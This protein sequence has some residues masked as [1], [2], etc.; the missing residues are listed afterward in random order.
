MSRKKA[1]EALRFD[2]DFDEGPEPTVAPSPS[3]KPA[4]L[5]MARAALDG[6]GPAEVTAPSLP[7]GASDLALS[8]SGF[9]ERLR[10]ALSGSFPD[11]LWV[12]G[13]IRKVTVRNG[14][15][16]LELADHETTKPEIPA[17]RERYRFSRP[18]RSAGAGRGEATLEVS[19]WSKDWPRI[20]AALDSVGIELAPGLVVRVCG[21]V[22][23][24]EA[25][26]RI[27]FSLSALDVE[28][29]VGGIAASRRRL[30]RT[31]QAEGII[32]ANRKL[33]LSP[34][35]LR[36]GLVTSPS[37]DAYNDFT[38]RLA[39][40]GIKF[41]TRFEPSL[42]QGSDA[43]PQIATALARL[44]QHRL[45]LIVLVRGG[46][47]RGDLAA[48]DHEAVARAILASRCP[49]WTGI[50]HTGDQSVADEV[51]HRSL[52]TPTACAEEVIAVVRRYVDDLQ[53]RAARV[54]LV[55]GRALDNASG[56]LDR[57]R[58]QL[59]GA[60]RHEVSRADEALA[61]ERA[62]LRQGA[63]LALE[64]CRSS[65]ARRCGRA[66]QLALARLVAEG[67]RLVSR[68]ALLDAFDPKRQLER[69]WSLTKGTDGRIIRTAQSVERGDRIVTILAEGSV[70]STVTSSARGADR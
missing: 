27:R 39:A 18:W 3:E 26:A 11:E 5:E 55:A 42:V 62:R 47:A 70:D 6:T 32:D 34:V 45:D 30:L 66:S 41:E 58:S 40:S 53:A 33:P 28:A 51:A 29:L 54:R 60:A 46:G 43:P 24:W 9:Y 4:G 63:A 16:Y 21:R 36:I 23:V 13:E 15:R 2:L 12:T 17:Y 37:S 68:R 57:R 25:G 10:L 35:P 8:I 48:F 59:A 52:V 69:G 61:G 67:D 7:G 44:R 50:G 19:C 1:A 64:K 56:S 31:L 14:N 49:V 38:G 20:A 65:L 22:S